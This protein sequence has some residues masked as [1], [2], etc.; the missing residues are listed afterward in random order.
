MWPTKP[1]PATFISDG[2]SCHYAQF[3][4]T[5]SSTLSCRPHTNYWQCSP[6]ILNSMDLWCCILVLKLSALL[7]TRMGQ[8]A[9]LKTQVCP[10]RS[11]HETQGI[12][13]ARLVADSFRALT[14]RPVLTQL[15]PSQY[16]WYSW[17]QWICCRL[18]RRKVWQQI[19]SQCLL[20]CKRFMEYFIHF[21]FHECPEPLP[22]EIRL[23]QQ[24]ICE[25]HPP[26]GSS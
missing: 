8:Q 16:I 15:P 12:P 7:I 24:F 11:C 5:S 21:P 14:A 23:S 25:L 22:A 4:N 9:E 1:T 6:R 19:C 26:S 3:P 13:K 20:H 18:S 2:S 17:F 10:R